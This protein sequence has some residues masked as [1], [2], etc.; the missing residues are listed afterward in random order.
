MRTEQVHIFCN[1]APN[2]LAWIGEAP[3]TK[4][5]SAKY[6]MLFPWILFPHRMVC[7]WIENVDKQ[8]KNLKSARVLPQKST[9][10]LPILSGNGIRFLYKISMFKSHVNLDCRGPRPTI[11]IATFP[12]SKKR[13]KKTQNF[14]FVSNLLKTFQR[15]IS[16]RQNQIDKYE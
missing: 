14:M 15:Q 3:W 8:G 10:I 12:K 2:H 7:A 6:K 16:Y 5:K 13:Y 11:T 4:K 1:G 9:F